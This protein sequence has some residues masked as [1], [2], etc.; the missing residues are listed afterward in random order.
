[1][2]NIQDDTDL[3]DMIKRLSI[4]AI[5]VEYGSDGQ[6]RYVF[7]IAP[8]KAALAALVA[9]REAL[10]VEKHKSE[11]NCWPKPKPD[12]YF[13]NHVCRTCSPDGKNPGQGCI[14]C[15]QTGYDQSPCPNCPGPVAALTTEAKGPDHES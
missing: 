5:A 15:R 11:H 1:M 4:T 8:L 14:N 6:K 2:S 13:H 10:A 12:P 7:D 3:D 9:R